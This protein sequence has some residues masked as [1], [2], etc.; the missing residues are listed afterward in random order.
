MKNKVIAIIPAKGN[1]RAIKKKNIRKI[2][3]KPLIYY[4]I[5]QAKKSKL[6]NDIV[7]ST[8]S[9]DIAK[10]S[11]KYGAK[12]PFIRPKY[13][14]SHFVPSHP[15]IKHAVLFMEKLNKY[16]YD[17][18]IMLQPTCPLRKHSDIDYSL[19]KLIKSKF[20]SIT[21]VVNVGGNH[22][23][24]MK[25]IKKNK[26]YNF[27]D[28]GFEDMRPR[29]KLKKIYI[30]NGAIYAST[31]DTVIKKNTL[32]ARKNLPHIMPEKRS[33]NI[34]TMSDLFTAEYY[35]KNQK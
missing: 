31:R 1:S 20:K 24:R 7:V 12:V 23:Y 3:G 8:D 9:K 17:Y 16:K 25:V 6:I 4:T 21:S 18:V 28:R 32:V 30:R 34:D 10:I 35:L 33:V 26:L 2:L 27:I 13:L 14:S 19:N 22:P 29:Q 11:K 15:V 5:I